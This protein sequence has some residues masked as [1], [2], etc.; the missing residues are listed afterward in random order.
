MRSQVSEVLGTYEYGHGSGWIKNYGGPEGT[1]LLQLAVPINFV[2]ANLHHLRRASNMNL[3]G[4]RLFV[5]AACVIL[6]DNKLL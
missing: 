1:G 2:I 5:T 4:S 3:T 6:K